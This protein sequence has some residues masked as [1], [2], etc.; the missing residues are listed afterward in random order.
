M[1]SKS[2][3]PSFILIHNGTFRF[4]RRTLWREFSR[5]F[6]IIPMPTKKFQVLVYAFTGYHLFIF[7]LQIC[8]KDENPLNLQRQQ[9]LLHGREYIF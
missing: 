1:I 7:P 2:R 8:E 5:S 4:R 3:Y 9:S 6:S